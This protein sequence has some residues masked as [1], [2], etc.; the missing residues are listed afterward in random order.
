M[1]MKQDVA[2]AALRAAHDQPAAVAAAMAMND[3]SASRRRGRMMLP[4]PQVICMC[5]LLVWPVVPLCSR[6]RGRVMLPAPQLIHMHSLSLA[7]NSTR[8]PRCFLHLPWG[9]S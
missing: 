9:K 2:K 4:A 1:L 8:M 6:R 5:P 7:C 3:A